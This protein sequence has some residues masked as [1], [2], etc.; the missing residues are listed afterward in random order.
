MYEMFE[1]STAAWVLALVATLYLI[2]RQ[3]SLQDADAQVMGRSRDFTGYE[4]Q[5]EDF[6]DIRLD[7]SSGSRP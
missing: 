1:L 2:V 6:P 3:M 5:D 7:G 4:E